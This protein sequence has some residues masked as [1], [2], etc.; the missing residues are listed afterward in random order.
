[1]APAEDQTPR[2]YK[3]PEY[4]EEETIPFFPNYVILEVIV[5]YLVLAGLI[6]LA[7]LLPA[8]LE[9]KA[10]PFHT[11]EHIKKGGGEMI[12]VRSFFLAIALCP[13]TS[14]ISTGR[15][16][17]GWLSRRAIRTWRPASTATTATG[18]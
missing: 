1:M 2:R 18:F 10:D 3:H 5:A 14:S 12:R 11:P 4:P 6:V 17:T 13:P 7:T 16:S 15:A 8:G 9:E